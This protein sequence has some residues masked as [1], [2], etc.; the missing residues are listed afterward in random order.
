MNTPLEKIGLFRIRSIAAA[1]AVPCVLGSSAIAAGHSQEQ[2]DL[3]R[4]SLID[5]AREVQ[6]GQLLAKSSDSAVESATARIDQAMREIESMLASS[7]GKTGLSEP[8]IDPIG[9]TPFQCVEPGEAAQ[10]YVSLSAAAVSPL[11]PAFEILIHGTQGFEQF[12]FVT[13]ITIPNIVAAVNKFTSETGVTASP[14][15]GGWADYRVRLQSV[16]AGD[17]QFVAAFI[18]SGPPTILF[19]GSSGVGSAHVWDF[20]IDPLLPWAAHTE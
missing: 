8:I 7:P 17:D 2:L 16:L 3:L 11:G 18:T 1:I 9:S 15:P 19:T 20:G 12:S 10:I 13:A 14:G 6:S 5:I 4:R